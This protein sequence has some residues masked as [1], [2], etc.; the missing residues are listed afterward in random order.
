MK[1]KTIQKLFIPGDEWLY[2]KVYCGVKT[3][4]FLL[5]HLINP[6]ANELLAKKIIDKWFFIRYSDPEPHLRVR[7]RVC[8]KK[9]IGNVISIMKTKTE[10]YVEDKQIWNIQLTTYIREIARYGE[11]TIEL[12]ESYFFYDTQE[13]INIIKN[14]STDEERFVKIFKF[15]ERIISLF[16][17]KAREQLLFLNKRQLQFK[18]EFKASKQ[19]TK[20]LNIKYQYFKTQLLEENNTFLLKENHLES[21]INHLLKLNKQGKMQVHIEDLLASYIHMTV[22][23]SFRS[24]Q[25]LCEMMLYDFLYKKNRSKYARYEAV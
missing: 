10:P 8:D 5:I 3:A 15:I 11:N 2:Y 20:E 16:K 22:N 14:S 6:I 4:D 17:F 7:F 9:N 1:T 21:I 25:R 18:Q 13:I 19:M 23:R 12:S 24:K